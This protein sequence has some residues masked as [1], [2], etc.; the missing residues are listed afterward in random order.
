MSTKQSGMNALASKT[1]HRVLSKHLNV[2]V[3][4]EQN[5][6]CTGR[7]ILAPNHVNLYDPYILL[8]WLQSRDIGFVNRYDRKD[9]FRLEF[10]ENRRRLGSYAIGGV[11]IDRTAEPGHVGY[12]R[13]FPKVNDRSAAFQAMSSRLKA[14]RAL[15]IFPEGDRSPDGLL[16]PLKQGI[17]HLALD[18]ELQPLPIVPIGLTYGGVYEPK[19]EVTVR[20]G[21]PFRAG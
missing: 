9:T 10:L 3:I 4:G 20:V 1:V 17:A 2:S 14:G 18:K 13:L 5:I 19:Q 6:P 12:S 8:G 15:C 21:E 16:H 7:C 11:T